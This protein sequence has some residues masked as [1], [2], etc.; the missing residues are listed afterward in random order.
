MNERAEYTTMEML[1]A[2]S[3][4]I[5][6]RPMS[7]RLWPS[8][9]SLTGGADQHRPFGY[10]APQFFAYDDKWAFFFCA[11]AMA[12][13]GESLDD[14]DYDAWLRYIMAHVRAHTSLNTDDEDPVD[15]AVFTLIPEARLIVSKVMEAMWCPT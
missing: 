7:K 2:F 14:R 3:E 8:M 15:E 13:A 1:K 11:E 12:E 5:C 4:R 6:A 10:S 9:I